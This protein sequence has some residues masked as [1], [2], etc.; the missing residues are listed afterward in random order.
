MHIGI[1]KFSVGI[2]IIGIIFIA[3]NLR[4]PLT[5]VGPLVSIIKNDLQISNTLAGIIT[6]LP[7]L[8][9]ALFSPI[10]PK[11]GRKFGVEI[12]ILIS[13]VFLTIGIIL[14]SWSGVATLYIGTAILGLAISVSNVLLPS[15]IKREFPSQIGLMTGVY[16]IS[17]D[18]IGANSF[19]DKHST[20]S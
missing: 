15:I 4:A 10:V 3:T 16:S 8:A 5:S 18:L 9:F 17:M 6:T 19:R 20:T 14:R 13:I 1:P 2:M 12:V 11:L 7:L